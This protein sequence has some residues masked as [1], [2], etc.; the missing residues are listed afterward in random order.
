MIFLSSD[1][2]SSPVTSP[3]L[4]PSQ[5]TLA[6]SEDAGSDSQVCIEVKKQSYSSLLSQ[7]YMNYCKIISMLLFFEQFS[8]PFHACFFVNLWVKV[9]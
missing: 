4:S 3:T 7:V 5:V 1:D 9:V 2:V 8:P 6:E